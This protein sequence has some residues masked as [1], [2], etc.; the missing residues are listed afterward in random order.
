[1]FVKLAELNQC[2]G[3]QAC[4]SAC[5]RG[6]IHMDCDEEGFLRP[7]AQS[8][9][10]VDCGLCEASCPI[11]C[12]PVLPEND[13]TA[14]AAY[15]RDE[16]LRAESSS[17]G[18]FSEIALEVL[19]QHGAVFGAA[20]DDRFKVIHICTEQLEELAKLR[21]AKY[22]QSDLG[23]TFL[24][25]KKRLDSKQFV[26]F[27]GTPC[28]VAGLK[29]FLRKEYDNLICV[30]F[31]CHGVPSPMAWQKYLEY[32][33]QLDDVKAP[34]TAVN[35][36]AKDSGWSRYAYSHQFQYA[37]GAVHSVRNSDSLFMKLF[38]GDYLSR[39]SCADCRF[40][41]YRHVSDITLGD[42]WGIWDIAPDMDDNRGTS[43]VL[44]H[45]ERGIQLLRQM[46]NRIM[47]KAVSLEEASRQ[48]PSMLNSSAPN[49]KRKEAFEIIKADDFSTFGNWFQPEHLTLRQRIGRKT[50][51]WLRKRRK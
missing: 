30:D 24:N 47:L 36:R 32:Q 23:D 37:D 6:C 22:T 42:F 5:P 35:M 39:E 28:Q 51:G 11:M 33:A 12:P 45:S 3:C 9:N 13:P 18:I 34:I 21:G 10:C 20:Y 4:A 40:K 2:T 46:K 43:V 27:S 15:S 50:A 19:K 44:C 29:A 41:G 17:G 48:N 8:S 1:M 38:V 16:R 14:Y 26:L 31:V 25:I 49:P 7:V